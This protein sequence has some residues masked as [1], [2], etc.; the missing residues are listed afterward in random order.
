MNDL[1]DAHVAGLTPVRS[2]ID[3]HHEAVVFMR[4]DCP[5]CRSEGLEG[6]SRVQAHVGTRS[7]I[8]QLFVVE[9]DL[10]A[11]GTVALSEAAW[12]ALSPQ[13]GEAARFSHPP[14]LDSM[15][16][17]RRKIYGE[18]LGPGEIQAIVQDI[19]AGRY[20]NVELAAFV[21]ASGG[22][23]MNRDEIAALTI[24]MVKAGRRLEWPQS[25]VVDK[26]C[27]GGLP[28]NRTTPIVVAIVAANGLLMPKTSSR[29]ITSPAGTADT[30]ETLAPVDLTLDAMR[31][32]VE[33]E[34]GCVVWGGA[35]ALS[36]ADDVL[37]RV[38][39]ALDIDSEGQLIAS[40][41]SKKAAAG[42]THVV[43]DIPVGPTAKVRSAAAADQLILGLRAA[44]Q[45]IGL[46]LHALVT[47][48]TQPVGRGI[49]PALEAHD[50]VRVLKRSAD[51]PQDL[52]ERA[53]VLAGAVLEMAGHAAPG[54]GVPLARATLDEGRAWR[55][56][57]A[58]CEAQG[59]LREPPV[60]PIREVVAAPASGR[61]TSVDCRRLARAAKLAGAPAAPAAGIELHASV[62]ARVAKGQ[63]LFTLHAQTRGELQYA[64]DYLRQ[65]PPFHGIEE[66][67]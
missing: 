20:S 63:P 4:R 23:R 44:A 38:E 8:A 21:A 54:H 35:V 13:P 33:R 43:I 56:F 59:G 52:R 24:A 7:V 17:V 58:I 19:A 40:V 26:H 9:G 67:P 25:L 62:G 2:G 64:L 41:L 50:V 22:T 29:A 53:L 34:N 65:G 3:A 55:K 28:G 11:P 46:K 14:T 36:P 32:V 49:G 30:M 18:T 42:S 12:T 37:I 66:A 10:I 61:I 45:A 57:A 51:A 16:A 1:H 15:S 60:A 39:R 48:G 6:H 31:S 5:V 47:D 27:V